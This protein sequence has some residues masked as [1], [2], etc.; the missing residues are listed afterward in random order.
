MALYIQCV[1]CK[2]LDRTSPGWDRCCAAFPLG[3][4][5][6]IALGVHDHWIHFPDDRGVRYAPNPD[7]DAGLATP[8]LS[9]SMLSRDVLGLGNPPVT[10]LASPPC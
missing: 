8:S 5:L 7:F 1:A 3:I 4:P 9:K 2:H 10:P 6:A